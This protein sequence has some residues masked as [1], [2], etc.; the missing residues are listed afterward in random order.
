[1]MRASFAA[2]LGSVALAAS[3]S[4]CAPVTGRCGPALHEREL[5]QIVA[6]DIRARGGEGL[7]T[8]SKVETRIPQSGCEYA[9]RVVPLPATP[10]DFI[11]VIVNRRGQVVDFISGY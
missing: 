1:M 9:V 8:S 4:A 3:Q 2:L 7:V 10:G 5:L 6:K 11:L